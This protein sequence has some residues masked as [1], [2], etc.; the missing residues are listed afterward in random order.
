[1]DVIAA[2]LKLRLHEEAQQLRIAAVAVDD[3]DFLETIA[4]DLFAGRVEHLPHQMAWQ[5]EGSRLVP[6]LINLPV[7]VIRED[8]GVFT[9]G[10]ARRVFA[11]LYQVRAHRRVRAV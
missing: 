2:S 5:G 7:E 9:F 8:D 10:D 6:R 11:N 1:D 4:G 3:Q